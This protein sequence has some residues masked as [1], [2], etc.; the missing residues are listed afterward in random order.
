[1]NVEVAVNPSRQA[2][3]H[4]SLVWPAFL[5]FQGGQHDPPCVVDFLE[6]ASDLQLGK[7]SSD[8]LDG[9]PAARPSAR[10]EIAGRGQERIGAPRHPPQ[11]SASCLL[12]AGRSC[13]RADGILIAAASRARDLSQS[14][15]ATR[16]AAGIKKLGHTAQ[17]VDRAVDRHGTN[18]FLEFCHIPINSVGGHIA[19]SLGI[20]VNTFKA[21]HMIEEI[22]IAPGKI[23]ARDVLEMRCGAPSP[24][25]FGR[26]ARG[27]PGRTR[28]ACG[29]WSNGRDRTFWRDL[30]DA[31]GTTG[32]FEGVCD[33]T[34]S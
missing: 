23:S 31:D 18:A 9:A 19:R 20:A 29:H 13:R 14:R 1:M 7:I 17:L 22:S 26:P 4:G 30:A 32:F 16:H 5:C 33:M 11:L 27:G 25:A 6:A 8:E 10:C 21:L 2:C 34:R 3:I 12:R 15:R 28:S 24:Q